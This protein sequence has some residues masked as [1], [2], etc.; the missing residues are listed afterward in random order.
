MNRKLVLMPDSKIMPDRKLTPHSLSWDQEI[1][2]VIEQRCAEERMTRSEY[3]RHCIR[4]EAARG[5]RMIGAQPGRELQ[6]A[7]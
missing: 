3:V 6:H 1:D 4:M 2:R 7:A 5:R